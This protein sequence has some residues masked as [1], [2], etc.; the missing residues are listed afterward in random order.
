VVAAEVVVAEVGMVFKIQ[1]ILLGR[2]IRPK[3]M[4]PSGPTIVKVPSGF[5]VMP[6]KVKLSREGLMNLHLG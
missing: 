6:K 3:I 2:E 1:L 5:N 4:M